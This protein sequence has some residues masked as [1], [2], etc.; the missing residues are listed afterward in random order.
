MRSHLYATR[1]AGLIGA[2]DF[3]R[4]WA[5]ADE[6]GKITHGLRSALAKRLAAGD[7]RTAR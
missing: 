3:E 7:N 2:G 4:L 6:I 1:S 5:R